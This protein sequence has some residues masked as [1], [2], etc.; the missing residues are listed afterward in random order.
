MIFSVLIALVATEQHIKCCAHHLGYNDQRLQ[1]GLPYGIEANEQPFLT[2]CYAG[3]P[4]SW[5]D[6]KQ[7]RVLCER[8][9]SFYNKR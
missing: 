9:L 4:L 8:M 7:S 5:G 1:V 3:G 6:E 2:M